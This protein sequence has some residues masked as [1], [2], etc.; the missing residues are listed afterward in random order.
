M[1]LPLSS[2]SKLLGNLG[3]VK[4]TPKS[5][6][7]TSS[8][9]KLCF[10]NLDQRNL[11]AA[12]SVE[13]AQ[14]D[15]SEFEGTAY[16]TVHI[17]RTQEDEQEQRT[18][19][20]AY[21]TAPGSA[22]ENED[23]SPRSDRL[24]FSPDHAT[25]QIPVP[26]IDDLVDELDETFTLTLSDPSEGASIDPQWEVT[27][28][29]IIDDD[30]SGDP[31]D[32]QPEINLL[33]EGMELPHGGSVDFGSTTVDSPVSRTFTVQ[34]LGNAT[35]TLGA[36][37]VPAG[38]SVDSPPESSSLAPGASTSFSLKLNATA[39]GTYSGDVT[40][41]NNDNPNDGDMENPQYIFEV[42]GDVTAPAG[43]TVSINDV[44]VVEG[45]NAYFN[46][47]L[48]RAL[49]SGEQ[50]TVQY[51]TQDGTAMSMFDCHDYMPASGTLTFLPG[52]PTS[53]QVTVDT[54]DDPIPEH[55][56]DFKVN[57]S[58]AVLA[59]VSDS[60]GVGLILND[61]GSPDNGVQLLVT[62][63]DAGNTIKV[64]L[65]DASEP[66]GGPELEFPAYNDNFQ[67]GV[68]VA[69]GDIN[70]DGFPDV[71]S[72]AGPTGGPHVRTFDGLTGAALPRDF[73]AYA[74]GMT[75]GIYVAAGDINGDGID[76]IVTAPDQGVAPHV[77]VFDG[78][79]G[80]IL[81][82]IF[83]YDMSFTGG[84]RVA[85]IISFDYDD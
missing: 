62:G 78:A 65:Y 7:S 84:V 51:A 15:V 85:I 32:P 76:D 68:R 35:L 55:D 24:T 18:F 57:L 22:T 6:R 64:R 79:T 71:I 70:G 42:R 31:D 66:G 27:T 61:D 48:S 1:L 34:N 10:E 81:K 26:I 13:S 50:V 74:I 38:F 2:W 37:N 40:L 25:M 58:N 53:Q 47:S 83:A 41:G 54:L 17:T 29:T 4:K 82:Q 56:E 69:T 45:Q 21:E 11:L 33:N 3:R 63:P 20:V 16:V 59:T 44:H 75:A 46:V 5:R 9:R 60:Q 73:F 52:Q 19:S 67:G 80:Q 8:R 12:F 72:G 30:E 49:L 28:I 23:Y 43:L 36:L 14:M 39:A 77:V